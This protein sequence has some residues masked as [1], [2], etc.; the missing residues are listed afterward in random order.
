MSGND[1]NPFLIDTSSLIAYC[2]TNYAY[3]V[4]QTLQ[5]ETSYVCNE[6]VK[7]Q[8]SSTNDFFHKRACEKYLRLLRDNR[9][10]DIHKKREDYKPGV[11]N[12]GEQTLEVLFRDNPDDVKYILLF[13]FDAIEN[14]E[15]VKE[16]IGGPALNTRIDLPNY[17]FERLRRDDV[18]TDNEYCKATYQMGVEEDWMEQHALKLDHVSDIDCPRFP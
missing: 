9:N 5:M 7:R 1:V 3:D 18:M 11:E 17:A 16:E 8:K 6:E 12:Q 2:K 15:H 13:D 10:P 14:F 4:F